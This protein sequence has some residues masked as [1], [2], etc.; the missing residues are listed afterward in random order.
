MESLQQP[1]RPVT[2]L[3]NRCIVSDSRDALRTMLLNAEKHCKAAHIATQSILKAEKTHPRATAI[4]ATQKKILREFVY[5]RKLFSG[6]DQECEA[7]KV[8]RA[9]YALSMIE[10][11]KT[12]SINVGRSSEPLQ[13]NGWSTGDVKKLREGPKNAKKGRKRRKMK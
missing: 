3:N 6:L 8:Y 4:E 5:M 2:R 11:S 12:R 13:T 10:L 1:V 7:R 9:R